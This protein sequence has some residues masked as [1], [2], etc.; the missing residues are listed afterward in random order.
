[1]RLM[2]AAIVAVF[3][4]V[5]NS[6][7]I[8]AQDVNLTSRDGKIEITGTLLGYDGEFY[9]LETI[10]GELTVDGSG[11]ICDGPGC[12]NLQGF[13]AD[14]SISGSASMAAILMPALVE[15]FAQRNGY[16]TQR[17]EEDSTHFRYALTDARTGQQAANFRHPTQPT[18]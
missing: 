7:A 6:P 13:V 2:W 8:Q 9:R 17:T 16:K 14:I 18:R 1:M 5:F 4:T 12:P 15:G 10:Y 11:V 3:L